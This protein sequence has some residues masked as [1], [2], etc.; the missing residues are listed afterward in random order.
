MVDSRE[1][2]KKGRRISSWKI[3]SRIGIGCYKLGKD[4]KRNTVTESRGVYMLL[5]ATHM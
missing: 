5:C 3:F 1:K 4:G 2:H